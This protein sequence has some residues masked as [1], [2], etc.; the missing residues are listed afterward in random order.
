VEIGTKKRYAETPRP[1]RLIPGTVYCV[2]SIST[3]EA[4]LTSSVDIALSMLVAVPGFLCVEMDE[5]PIQLEKKPIGA[6]GSNHPHR[7]HVR[8]RH[9]ASGASAA[10]AR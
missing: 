6:S 2:H 3:W 1:T 5:R 9:Q 7:L 10:L 4:S 8:M